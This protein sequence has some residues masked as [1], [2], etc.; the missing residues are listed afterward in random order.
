MVSQPGV[1]RQ[2]FT[3]SEG[4]GGTLHVTSNDNYIEENRLEIL[5]TPPKP[6]GILPLQSWVCTRYFLT[7]MLA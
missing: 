7:S 2:Q 5:F 6:D 4:E 1:A 3:M